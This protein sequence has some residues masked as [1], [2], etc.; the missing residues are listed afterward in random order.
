M[1]E[2]EKDCE[3]YALIYGIIIA[4]VLFGLAYAGPNKVDPGPPLIELLAL[5]S[6]D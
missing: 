5:E 1:S 3:R 6:D 4:L 2:F